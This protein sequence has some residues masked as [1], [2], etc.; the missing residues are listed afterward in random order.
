MAI[1]VENILAGLK[2]HPLLAVNTETARMISEY[3]KNQPQNDESSIKGIGGVIYLKEE[4]IHY[5]FPMRFVHGAPLILNTF[6]SYI[7]D[8]MESGKR[9]PEIHKS[10]YDILHKLLNLFPKFDSLD[11][12]G[13]YKEHTKLASMLVLL[14]NHMTYAHRINEST[15]FLSN[16]NSQMIE[17]MKDMLGTQ[18]RF[19][20]LLQGMDLVASVQTDKIQ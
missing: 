20:A 12:S 9:V 15:Q 19:E 14:F 4:N 8:V 10:A 11:D 3:I 7:D 1:P 2:I 6:N 16:E 18:E 5:V 17:T 13:E